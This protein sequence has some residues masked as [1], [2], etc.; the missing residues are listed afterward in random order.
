MKDQKWLFHKDCPEGQIFDLAEVE[1]HELEDAG[2]VQTPA[3]LDIPVK[4]EELTQKVFDSLGP[5]D[6]INKVK[7]MGY[8]V[9]T[10]DELNAEVQKAV[11][12]VKEEVPAVVVDPPEEEKS[13]E[14]LEQMYF[15]SPESLH[16]KELVIYA[17]SRFGIKL[18]MTMKE[19]TMIGKINEAKAE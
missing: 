11:S 15:E 10:P 5:Q 18:T 19:S 3:L 16:K 7:H 12:E 6:L 2:W 13:L 4:E 9:M 17:K 8:L 14:V 1:E